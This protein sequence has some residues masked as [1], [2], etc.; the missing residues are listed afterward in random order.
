MRR[1]GGTQWV[2]RVESASGAGPMARPHRN[3]PLPLH[4]NRARDV[5]RRSAPVGYGPKDDFD[6]LLG[7]GSSPSQVYL[8]GFATREQAVDWFGDD[9]LRALA[10][11]GYEL[12]Q[13]PAIEVRHSKSGRQVAFIPHP[14]YRVSSRLP[15]W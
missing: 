8:Y 12:K 10:E 9:A 11:L 2:W 4:H 6:P 3:V 15:P 13:V 5:S 14:A 7:R 1:F